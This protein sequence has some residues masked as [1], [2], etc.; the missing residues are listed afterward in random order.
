MG[1]YLKSHLLGNRVN[2]CFLVVFNSF[3]L[4]FQ[5]QL[6]SHVS[7]KANAQ[8]KTLLFLR[9]RGRYILSLNILQ[10]TK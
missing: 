2:S 6:N 1:L 9:M 4:S 8:P 7:E 10:L 5:G 3:V